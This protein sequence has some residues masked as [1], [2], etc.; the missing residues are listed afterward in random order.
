MELHMSEVAG[1]I[2]SKKHD[3]GRRRTT[4]GASTQS[5]IAGPQLVTPE[6]DPV[7]EAT[8]SY[9]HAALKE[10]QQRLDAARD[11]DRDRQAERAAD[12]SLEFIWLETGASRPRQAAPMGERILAML[13]LT[14]TTL[15]VTTI[16]RQ[17]LAR[18]Q[19]RLAQLLGTH[20]RLACSSF[21]T[22]EEM[23]RE[24]VSPVDG[25]APVVPPEFWA[26]LEERELR[27]WID[28]SIPALGGLTPRQAVETAEGRRAVLDLI[29]YMTSDELMGRVPPG[30]MAPDYRK[31]KKMLGL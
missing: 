27:S 26:E 11:F 31:V 19:R 18:C 23:L 10:I 20:I 7:V 30:A 2:M 3:H 21:K 6:G 8:A 9:Q 5:R 4:T 28:E 24:P 17:R 12:G 25:A 29:D 16:S 13:S 14:P 15:E 22:V 1:G